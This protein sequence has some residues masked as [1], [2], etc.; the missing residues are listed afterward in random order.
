MVLYPDGRW[1]WADSGRFSGRITSSTGDRPCVACGLDA[2]PEG[3]DACL[4]RIPGAQAAC[5]GHGVMPPYVWWDDGT[6]QR[7]PDIDWPE[8]IP[9][10]GARR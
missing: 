7:G 9:S 2:T 10:V 3:F 1:R 6:V 5:C 4:G 8:G